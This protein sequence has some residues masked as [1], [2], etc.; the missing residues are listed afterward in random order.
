MKR[1][2]IVLLVALIVLMVSP[3]TTDAHTPTAGANQLYSVSTTLS[4]KFSASAY[5]QWLID[6]VKA[7]LDDSQAGGSTFNNGYYN[8][9]KMP[10][11]VYSST[12]IGQI[13]YTTQSYSPCSGVSAWIACG[14][15]HGGSTAFDIYIRVLTGTSR[16]YE[17]DVND[18]RHTRYLLKLAMVHEPLHVT[19]GISNH[20]PQTIDETVMITPVIPPYGDHGWSTTHI[21]A[22]D[23]AAGQLLYDLETLAGDYAS[24]FDHITNHGA[25][26]LRSG[27]SVSGA[28]SLSAC[29]GNSVTV[30]GRLE[31]ADYA[32]YGRLALN[33]LAGRTVTFDR[34]GVSNTSSVTANNTS[35]GD[36][37]SASFS[38]ATYGTH[39]YD[40]HFDGSAAS[41]LGSASG[42][43]FTVTWIPTNLC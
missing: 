43:S 6:A 17:A 19:M 42:G 12:G 37:W 8:G 18:T 39:S 21:Q 30:S 32:S 14:N 38:S 13:H 16:W 28:T 31:V 27:L 1:Q 35:S 26:G 40:V 10:R 4:W 5:P 24:C 22:C 34:D 33:P 7:S 36:N 15:P 25:Y 11:F 29:V 2:S 9:T 20:D 41:S 23:E 3:N